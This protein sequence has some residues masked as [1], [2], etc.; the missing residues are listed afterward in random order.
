MFAEK[1]NSLMNIAEVSNSSLSRIIHINSSH[2]GRLRSG[3][4]PLPKKHEYLSSICLYL[5]EHLKKDYQITALQKLTGIGN[6]ALDTKEKTALYLE[7]WLLN[8]DHDTSPATGR[9]ISGF[10]H[11]SPKTS[12]SMFTNGETE[13]NLASY[14][15]HLYGNAGKRQAVEQFFLLILQ[16][17]KPQT[18]L[19]FSDEN[20]SWLYEDINFS[21]R[22][23]ELFTKV[24]LKGNRIKIIHSISRDL[25]E[26]IEAVQKWIPIYMTG[27]IEPYYYPRIRDG[28]FQ[29]T[30]FIAPNTA[31]VISS[32]IKQETEGMLNI[33]LTDKSAL[34][35][36]TKKYEQ[37]LSLCRPL[38][39]IFT[40]RNK[41][42]FR[43]AIEGFLYADGDICL[44][45]A[46]PPLF[47]MPKQLVKEL[48]EKPGNGDLLELW[49]LCLSSFQK[50]IKNQAV[51]ITLPDPQLAMLKPLF[52]KFPLPKLFSFKEFAYTKE[53]YLLHLDHLQKLARRYK[54]L[55][56]TL[57]NDLEFNMTLYI[58]EDVVV[59]MAKTD[60]PVSAFV[61]NEH[62]M[63]N[64]F[65]DYL[66][67][68]KS[69]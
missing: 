3:A 68:H 31:A 54:N 21:I 52:I 10:S 51:S 33:F 53:Q 39:N 58:K 8:Q 12:N 37:Y 5:A 7:H 50:T 6:A 57:R 65:W 41:D 36:L 11:F 16:E 28:V 30:M 18:I 26:I 43:K 42:D 66:K 56:V 4:R 49:E 64:A 27:M 29:H 46:V 48:A 19:L 15:K 44:Y 63:I 47:A 55:T 40:E 38:M 14:A 2:I 69:S 17:K 20:M 60:N 62:N 32:S 13:D 24:I 34:H 35:A 25:N 59:I 22:W 1:F 67:N 9:L 23:K 61:I 45:C